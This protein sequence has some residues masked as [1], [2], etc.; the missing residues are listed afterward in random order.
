LAGDYVIDASSSQEWKA[1][2]IDTV[3]SNNEADGEKS[4]TALCKESWDDAPTEPAFSLT[5]EVQDRTVLVR[6][7]CP[8]SND[9]DVFLAQ[10][11]G[12]ILIQR[13]GCTN[14]FTTV[15]LPGEDEVLIYNAASQE[16]VLTLFES[17]IGSSSEMVELS[18]MV[19]QKGE[20]LGMVPRKLVHKA[21]ILHR[22]VGMVVT[23]NRPILSPHCKDFPDLY[24]HRRTDTKRIFPSLYDMFVGGVSTTGEEA[25]TTAQREVAEELGLVRA[26]SD[27]NM[28]SDALFSCVICTSYNRCFVTVFC[29]TFL[30]EQDVILLQKEEVAWGDFVAYDTIVASADLS[31]ERLIENRS[32]PG[33][34]PHN[35]Q[36]RIAMS[37]AFYRRDDMKGREWDYVPD[38]L[39]VWETWLE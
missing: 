30:D 14:G 28:L 8:R 26:L 31:I 12:R 27:P 13:L 10:I 9:M 15:I 39:L 21:N 20:A 34:I 6:L 38:G 23:R 7:D 33:R 22:G 18:D 25:K 2:R 3:V 5:A 24:V 19:D 4:V 16:G 29:C 17:L 11:L 36:D 35:I 1:Y 32:W 37:N